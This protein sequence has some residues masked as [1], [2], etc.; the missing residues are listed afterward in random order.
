MRKSAL[1]ALLGLS[2]A[3]AAG[4]QEA[5]LLP[6]TSALE[7]A[8]DAVKESQKTRRFDF[9]FGGFR[10]NRWTLRPDVTP[11]GGTL[12]IWVDVGDTVV[13][14]FTKYPNPRHDVDTSV[15]IDGV[16]AEVDGVASDGVHILMRDFGVEEHTASFKAE[17]PGML[18][19][20]SRWGGSSHWGTIIVKKK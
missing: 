11:P 5:G 6:L 1:L 8:R 7:S 16:K 12:T 17:K 13:L 18:L 14:N 10:G 4:A 19:L 15:D 2:L 20:Y 3:G 9:E